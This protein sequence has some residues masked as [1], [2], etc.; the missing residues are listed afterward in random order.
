[1]SL[2]DDADAMAQRW[3]LLRID[4]DG[5]GL[6]KFGEKGLTLAPANGDWEP[7]E[8]QV[9]IPRSEE[10]PG[11]GIM[12]EEF[13]AGEDGTGLTLVTGLAEGGNAAL[14]GV[15]LLPGDAIVRAGGAKTEGLNYDLTIDALMGMPP[16]PSAASITVKRL[17]KIHACRC[18]VVFPKEEGRADK[19]IALFPGRNIRQA[20]IMNGVEMGPCNED[21]Q[22]LCDCGMVV[23]KGRKHLVP[24]GSQ[25]RQMLKKEK[26]WRLTCRAKVAPLEQEEEMVIRIRPDTENIMRPK[27]PTAWRT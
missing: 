13:G 1:M 8:I 7:R 17:V 27:D 3:K 12:L 18:T 26:D 16:A 9:E 14:A 10:S 4:S 11:L 20:L 5:Q 15:D 22:C 23:R 21:L 24:E 19:I 25:E 6:S 2:E